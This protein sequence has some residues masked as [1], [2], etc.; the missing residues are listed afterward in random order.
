[1]TITDATENLDDVPAAI[2]ATNDRAR[3]R[4]LTLARHLGMRTI[5]VAER[6]RPAYHAAASIASNLIMPIFE[7]AEHMA[8]SAAVPRDTFRPL[9]CAAVRNWCERGAKLALTGPIARNDM[10]TV[11]I[12]RR[13]ILERCPDGVALFD[14]LVQ[15]T[16]QLVSERR[17][18]ER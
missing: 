13:A 18:T 4:A 3:Q 2:A 16:Q 1:M 7:L 9:I 12:Q 15:A 11:G 5:T 17:G 10:V 8:R 6:D 14:N